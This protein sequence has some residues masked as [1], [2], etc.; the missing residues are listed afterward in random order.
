MF[1]HCYL[2]KEGDSED[3]DDH[4]EEFYYTEIEMVVSEPSNSPSATSR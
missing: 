3:S 2:G 1:Y 4:E